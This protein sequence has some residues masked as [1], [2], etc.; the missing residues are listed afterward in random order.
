MELISGLIGKIKLEIPLSRL[1]S[2]NWLI[3]IH[4]FVLLVTPQSQHEVTSDTLTN[5]LSQNKNKQ[6][7]LF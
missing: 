6:K 1:S 4:D 5:I 7:I 2:R 3:S